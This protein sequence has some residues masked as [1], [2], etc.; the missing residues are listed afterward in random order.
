MTAGKVRA[1]MNAPIVNLMLNDTYKTTEYCVQATFAWQVARALQISARIA[2]AH[3]MSNKES[4][5]WG[6]PNIT[7]GHWIEPSGSKTP[8]GSAKRGFFIPHTNYREKED[9]MKNTIYENVLLVTILLTIGLSYVS[10]LRSL[11]VAT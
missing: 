4:M 10:C 11:V 2:P 7:E 8:V 9:D 5:N 3:G 1:P 6:L